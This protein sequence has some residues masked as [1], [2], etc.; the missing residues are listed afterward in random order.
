MQH[1]HPPLQK[2]QGWGTLIRNGARKDSKRWATR[3]DGA[4]Y[5]YDAAGNRASKTNYIN[6]VTSN[7]GYDPLYELTQVTQGASTTESYSYDAVGNRLSSSGVPSYSYNT[8][9]E[10]TQNSLGSYSYDA[11]GNTLSDPSGKTYTWDFENRLVQAVVPGTNGGTTTFRYDPFGRRIYKQSPS[12]TGSFLYDG[13]NLIET[14]NGSGS[15]VASYAHGDDLDQPFAEFRSG[16]PSYYQ[17]DAASSVTSL[18]NSTGALANTYTYD[19]FGNLT[20]STGTLRSPFQYTGRE[21]DSETSLYYYRARY[22]DPSTG[23]FI[24][25]DP[26]GFQAGDS[27]FYRYAANDPNDY[28]D[29]SGNVIVPQPG[30]APAGG[31]NLTYYYAALAYL[32]GDA[33][34]GSVIRKLQNSPRIFTLNFGN[35]AADDSYDPNSRSIT[36]APLSGVAC[37]NNCRISPALALCHEMAHAAGDGPIAR[38]LAQTPD[39]QYDNKEE[40]RV[41]VN[42]ENPFARRNGE[43]VR[44]DH[45]G[46]PVNVPTPTSH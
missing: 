5:T 28:N 45:G 36:W 38:H 31:L 35:S 7:Y 9:N 15:E 26:V 42:Y 24:S 18:S 34:C 43:C 20:N 44:N 32:G 4:S 27:D 12:F 14:V 33:G 22:I 16:T 30:P 25:E 2:T 23:R 1:R 41:I 21:F 29:P 3:L 17:A 13:A 8:S 10:L 11:N 37:G 6:G 46:Q 40:R 39:N 19:S